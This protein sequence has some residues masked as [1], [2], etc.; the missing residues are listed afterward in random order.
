MRL[1]Q[2][3]AAHEDFLSRARGILHAEITAAKKVVAAL[4]AEAQTAKAALTEFQEQRESAQKQV[5][6]IRGDLHQRSTLA[7]VQADIEK[8]RKVLA[9]LQAD[10][11]RATAAKAA[12]EKQCTAADSRLV[13]LNL[14][15]NRMIAIRTE[16]ESVM[17]GLR[18][19]L[20]QVSLGQRP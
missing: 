18:A 15:A 9:T 3:A 6:A 19:Q 14:E 7:G 8:G 1:D 11:E 4:N 12:V 17:A 10:I 2:L 5:A 13:A 20:A 16:G